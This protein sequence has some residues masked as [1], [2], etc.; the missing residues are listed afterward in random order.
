MLGWQKLN[1]AV[2]AMRM[3]SRIACRIMQQAS[4]ASS[5]L[6]PSFLMLLFQ[7]NK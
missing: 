2:T 4:Q 6:A 3:I 5:T 1:E 7:K